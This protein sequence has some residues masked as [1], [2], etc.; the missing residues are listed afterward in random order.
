LVLR[1]DASGGYCA[2]AHALDLTSPLL[3]SV[4]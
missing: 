4:S 2:C 3:G 1:E